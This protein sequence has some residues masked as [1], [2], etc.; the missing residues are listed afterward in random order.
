M[1]KR[2]IVRRRG[3]GAAGYRS[4]SHRHLSA[5]VLPKLRSGRARVIDLHHDPGH[6]APM[7]K[8][9][10]NDGLLRYML[11]PEGLRVGDEVLMGEDAPIRSGNIL[12][13]S[14]IP[15]GTP[16][17]HIE[18]NPLDGGRFV[19]AGGTSATIITRGKKVTV[20]LPSGQFKSLSGGCRAIVGIVSGGG[21]HELPIGKAGKMYH[22]NRS[23]AKIWPRVSGVSM[24]PVNHPHG[25]GNHPHIG[26][27]STVSRHA[28]PGRKVGRL[29]PKKRDKKGRK[30]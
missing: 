18:A 12:P 4:P 20:Q 27:P 13:L 22:M 17:Y 16:I 7:A 8:L 10:W 11:A 28:P 6:T 14:I 24:N 21:R 1:G 25:G 15:E 29:S 23:H 26:K 30:G 5:A 3:K 2:I 9:L 19:K